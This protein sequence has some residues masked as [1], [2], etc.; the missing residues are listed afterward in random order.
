MGYNYRYTI[1]YWNEIDGSDTIETGFVC[2]NDCADATSKLV[3]MYGEDYIKMV[4][5]AYYSETGGVI[6]DNDMGVDSELIK[7]HA[8]RIIE[9]TGGIGGV[10]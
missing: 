4:S 9:I 7:A 5:I 1:T 3:T 10:E 8:E 6:I 2:G